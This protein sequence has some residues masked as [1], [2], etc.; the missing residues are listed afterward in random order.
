MK[1]KKERNNSGFTL[2]ELMIAIAILGFIV[3]P[4]MHSFVTAARTNAKAQ[5]IQNATM[6]ATN[7]MEEVKANDME[8][9]AFQF[10][11][12]TRDD[13]TSRFDIVGS[14]SNVYELRMKDSVLQHV[15]KYAENGGINNREHVTSSVLYKDYAA[16][17]SDEYEFLGQELGKYYFAMEGLEA[18]AST[19]DALITVDAAAYKTVDEKGYNDQKTVSIESLDV[20]EDAF[21]V[22]AQEQDADSAE[23][24]A[25]AANVLDYQA[26][27]NAMQRKITIDIEQDGDLN[28]VYVT[29]EYSYAGHTKRVSHL[30]YNNS[31][32]PDFSLKS[33]YLFY[34]PHYTSNQEEIIINNPDNV[35]V[36]VHLIKQRIPSTNTASLY[37]KETTYNCRVT[38]N[39][40]VPSYN[41]SS[42]KAYTTI[43]TNLGYNLYRENTEQTSQVVYRYSGRTGDYRDDIAG[44]V[45]KMLDVKLLDGKDDKDRIYEVTV[46]IYKEGEAANL[47]EGDPVAKITGS[48][49]H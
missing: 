22:Q 18:G 32:S 13:S 15:V 47:F 35:K 5:Q 46:A 21:Y 3:G 45:T 48:K 26:V 28:R 9:L 36:N 24:L 30:I 11:Y 37:T 23:S 40:N 31:E 38:V 1:Q 6:L 29:Y 7:L 39:E 27:T 25:N 34:V 41:A 42:F 33:I 49:D 19:Y 43:R 14:Y 44:V 8:D 12:P 4:F 10:N 17:L 20:L 2:V 16:N